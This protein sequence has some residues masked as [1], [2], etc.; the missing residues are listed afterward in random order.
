VLP[1]DQLAA[2]ENLLSSPLFIAY[3]DLFKEIFSS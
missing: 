1:D 3:D 2:A